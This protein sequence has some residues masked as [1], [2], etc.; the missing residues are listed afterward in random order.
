MTFCNFR[1]IIN[2]GHYYFVLSRRKKHE[3]FKKSISIFLTLTIISSIFCINVFAAKQGTVYG[4]KYSQPCN[5]TLTNTRKS[6]SIR[7]SYWQTIAAY[8]Y[9]WQR[10]KIVMYNNNGKYITSWTAKSGDVFHLGNDNKGYKLY[11]V[12]WTGTYGGVRIKNNTVVGSY[13]FSGASNCSYR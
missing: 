11:V 6:A 12:G 2:S 3:Y 10:A 4:G 1:C 9:P 5:I 13:S 7:F 8:G